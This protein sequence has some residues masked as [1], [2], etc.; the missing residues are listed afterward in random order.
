[1]R[2]AKFW[3]VPPTGIECVER[4]MRDRIVL[5][6]AQVSVESGPHAGAGEMARQR[7]KVERERVAHNLQ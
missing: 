2:R 7:D 5:P 3:E 4:V 1:M 6:H